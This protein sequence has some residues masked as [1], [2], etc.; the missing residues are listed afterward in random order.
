MSRGTLWTDYDWRNSR[1][2]VYRP[3]AEGVA[4]AG[5]RPYDLRHS[6]ASLLIHEGVS[7]IEVARQVGNS[8]DVTLTTYAHVF[9]EFEPTERVGACDAIEAAREEF[10]V[11]GRYA[12]ALDAGED[13]AGDPASVLEA[14]ARTRTA[15]PFITSEVLYQLSYVGA[16]GL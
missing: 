3:T 5:T 4:L 15:D 14:D 12:A 11:R 10:D 9:E 1:N 16:G 13:E 2:R 7:V 8:A 6:F